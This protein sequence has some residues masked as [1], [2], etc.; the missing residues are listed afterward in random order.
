MSLEQASYIFALVLVGIWI[1]IYIR[2]KTRDHHYYWL[3]AFALAIVL[4]HA[5]TQQF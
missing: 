2:Y 3:V 4:M 1:I 5:F